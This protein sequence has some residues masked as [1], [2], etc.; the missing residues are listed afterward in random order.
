MGVYLFLRMSSYLYKLGNLYNVQ[1][2]YDVIGLGKHLRLMVPAPRATD[3]KELIK[4]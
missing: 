1:V 3:G 4:K 2:M